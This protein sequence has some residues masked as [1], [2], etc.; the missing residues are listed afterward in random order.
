MTEGCDGARGLTSY[1]QTRVTEKQKGKHENP[2]QLTGLW[3]STV[4][5]SVRV[6]Q[7]KEGAQDQ[8]VGRGS[9]P[10]TDLGV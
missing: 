9:F 1:L 4:P 3:R 6:K 8:W 7:C 2:A 10:V 5:V